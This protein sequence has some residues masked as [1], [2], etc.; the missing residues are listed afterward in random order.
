MS[1]ILHVQDVQRAQLE[2]Q[3]KLI[4]MQ[5]KLLEKLLARHEERS[6][7]LGASQEPLAKR[8]PLQQRRVS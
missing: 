1:M 6:S 5:S 4:E 8:S 7:G 2:R 3:N